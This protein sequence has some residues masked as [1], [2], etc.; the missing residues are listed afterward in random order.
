MQAW[1]GV[2]VAARVTVLFGTDRVASVET[3]VVVVGT[4]A[5]TTD[6]AGPLRLAALKVENP[7]LL[8]FYKSL[9]ADQKEKFDRFR[10]RQ[11]RQ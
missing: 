2:T 11:D 8:A 3:S 6:G 10:D 1:F 4:P 9:D 5:I 7:K